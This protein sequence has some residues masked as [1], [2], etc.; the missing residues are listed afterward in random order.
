M[1]LILTPKAS[2]LCFSSFLLIYQII[3]PLTTAGLAPLLLLSGLNIRLVFRY[4]SKQNKII[5]F[6]EVFASIP[7]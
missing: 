2:Q 4:E 3:H 5:P 6:K 7:F 1:F